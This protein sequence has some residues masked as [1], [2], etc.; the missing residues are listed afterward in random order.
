MSSFHIISYDSMALRPDLKVTVEAYR[1]KFEA[2]LAE[3][4]SAPEPVA[5]VEPPAPVA[6]AAQAPAVEAAGSVDKPRPKAKISPKS[7]GVSDWHSRPALSPF[8]IEEAVAS[9]S[10]GAYITLDKSGNGGREVKLDDGSEA[11]VSS[12]KWARAMAIRKGDTLYLP[13]TKNKCFWRGIVESRTTAPFRPATKQTSYL[14][15][16][17]Q[18]AT[19]AG[20][21]KAVASAFQFGIEGEIEVN[22]SVKWSRMAELTP[23][24]ETYLKNQNKHWPVATVWRLTGEAPVA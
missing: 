7:Y 3:A 11:T 24:W 14:T 22:W 17:R 2:L 6:E 12:V 13:D 18:R 15:R 8:I 9:S 19:A 1:L 5:E 4:L 10:F 20:K 23:E 21:G 16:V